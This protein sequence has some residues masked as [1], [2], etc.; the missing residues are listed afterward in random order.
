M[1]SAGIGQNEDFH[2]DLTYR[3]DKIHWLE[4]TTSNSSERLFLN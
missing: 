4:T 1:K 3:K 2:K